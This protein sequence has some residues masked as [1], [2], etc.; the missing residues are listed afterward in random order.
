VRF[1]FLSQSDVP[2]WLSLGVVA[3]LAVPAYL[4]AQYLFTTGKRLKD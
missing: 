4:W 3:A 1:G 2:I